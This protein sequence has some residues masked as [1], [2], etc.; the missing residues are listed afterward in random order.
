MEVVWGFSGVSSNWVGNFWVLV[1]A[2]LGAGRRRQDRIRVG[3]VVLCVYWDFGLVW[4]LAW[5]NLDLD[6]IWYVAIGQQFGTHSMLREIGSVTEPFFFGSG[7][8][9]GNST[10]RDIPEEN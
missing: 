6:L 4:V 10:M 5:G 2:Y 9:G 3:Y 7:G 8:G 1:Y